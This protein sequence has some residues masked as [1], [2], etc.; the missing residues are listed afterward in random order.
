MEFQL[1]DEQKQLY[2]E[3]RKFAEEEMKPV[4]TE[5]DIDE[6]YPH[7]ITDKAADMGLLVVG[8]SLCDG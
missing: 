8:L 4:A 1:T 3:V 7:E 6:K 5:Y 2:E